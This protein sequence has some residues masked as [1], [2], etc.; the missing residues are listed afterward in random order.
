MEDGYV[1]VIGSASI[2]TTAQPNRALEWGLP[3]PGVIRH[4][5]GGVARNIAENLARL[6]I[7]TYLITAIGSDTNGARIQR[8]CIEAGIDC[9]LFQQVEGK[10][11]ANYMKLFDENGKGMVAVSDFDI[12]DTIDKDLILRH[13]DLIAE[14][15]MI[16][17]DATL[18]DTT[19]QAIFAIS[20]ENNLRVAADPT[21]P[22]LAGRLCPYIDQLFLIVPNASE[23]NSLCGVMT[24]AN[25]RESAITAARSLVSMGAELAV[26][27]MGESGLAYADSGGSGFIKAIKTDVVDTAGAGDAFTGAV[28]F[29]VLNGVQVDEAM[30]L[31]VTAASLTLESRQTV[32]PTL[33]QELL[34]DNLK[35]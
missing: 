8:K 3:N 12:V 25:D 16:V 6:E 10:H 5:V 4:R 21:T 9:S 2:D 7:P 29:G 26:V 11:S 34:F 18:S 13:E 27:T 31:G 28:I 20:T 23:T 30:R 17:V 15:E 14:A 24:Q 22:L 33:T 32:L 19:L 35:S 1:V